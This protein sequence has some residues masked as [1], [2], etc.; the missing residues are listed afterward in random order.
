VELPNLAIYAKKQEKSVFLSYFYAFL[1][2][3]LLKSSWN[4][5]KSTISAFFAIQPIKD[6]QGR[7][8]KRLRADTPPFQASDNNSFGENG[9]YSL[10]PLRKRL[11]KALQL[12]QFRVYQDKISTPN[13]PNLDAQ[14]KPA[15]V[16]FG[17]QLG[18][19][20]PHIRV[21]IPFQSE[22]E[23]NLH[24]NPSKNPSKIGNRKP[25]TALLLIAINDTQKAPQIPQ[26]WIKNQ[27]NDHTSLFFTLFLFISY[28]FR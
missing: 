16:L 22:N 2:L 3:N 11:Q 17:S 28:L 26:N 25:L 21:E 13:S 6:A 14:N 27:P 23:A 8:T 10:K 24:Q 9:D 19:I 5:F 18:K 15:P 7:L 20:W 1:I 4:P 12:P